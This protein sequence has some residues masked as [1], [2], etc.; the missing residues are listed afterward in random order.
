MHFN[1]LKTTFFI[2]LSLILSGCITLQKSTKVL[3]PPPANFVPMEMGT[4]GKREISDYAK[5]R[6]ELFASEDI[7]KLQNGNV[8]VGGSMT[9]RYPLATHYPGIV[10]VNRGIGGDTIGGLAAYGVYDRLSSSIINLNPSK[11]ILLVGINDLIWV[12]SVSMEKK[13][14]QYAYL[15]WTIR[16]NLPDTQLYLI[17]NLP[18]KGKLAYVN[19]DAER[20]NLN[21]KKIAQIYGAQYIDIAPY[22]RDEKGELKA[23]LATDDIHINQAGYKIMTDLYK[24]EIFQ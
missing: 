1:L 24:K 9:E 17:S 10:V 22:F 18:C 14:D 3:P 12:K 23:E 15:V 21:I 8:F 4:E 5:K 6:M 16:K 7:S 13:I 2:S 11:L 19:D 20:F